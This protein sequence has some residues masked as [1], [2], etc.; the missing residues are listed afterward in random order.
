[1]PSGCPVTTSGYGAMRVILMNIVNCTQGEYLVVDRL[2][3]DKKDPRHKF[4][5]NGIKQVEQ[6]L[7]TAK[8][9]PRT[10]HWS[11]IEAGI[12]RSLQGFGELQTVPDVSKL[13]AK[14]R[15]LKFE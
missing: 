5:T 4:W 15:H 11:E 1:M 10:P 8:A 13:F 3:R 12:G 2:I 6:A 9:R 7:A 14:V